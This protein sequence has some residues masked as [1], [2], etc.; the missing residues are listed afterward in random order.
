[1]S[2]SMFSTFTNKLFNYLFLHKPSN[3]NEWLYE[4]KMMENQINKMLGKG[5]PSELKDPIEIRYL[6][7]L[8]LQTKKLLN[9]KNFNNINSLECGSGTGLFSLYLAQEGANSTLIDFLDLCLKY[10][11]MI[12][13]YMKTKSSSF[14]RVEFIKADFL[15]A[16]YK[17]QFDF[18]HN[19]GIVE[20]FNE[21]YSNK[22]IKKMVSFTKPG[23]WVMVGVPNYF[24]PDLINIWRLYGKGTER[25]FTTNKLR[26]LLEKNGLREIKTSF[27]TFVYPSFVPQWFIKKTSRIEDFLGQKMK[28]GFLLIGLGKK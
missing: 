2:K 1:M 21:E 12:H 16:G 18:V 6:S 8:I 11:K 27:S 9:L 5:Y 20:H 7:K 14:G 15:T 10:S 28:L 26:E 3:E 25:Y 4:E 17:N 24:C 22:V 13:Q 23:G 19:I